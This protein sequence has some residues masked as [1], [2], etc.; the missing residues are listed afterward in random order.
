MASESRSGEGSV[1]G[2][3]HPTRLPGLS[4]ATVVDEGPARVSVHDRLVLFAFTAGEALVWCRG[5]THA[6]A[7]GSLLV[8]EPGDVHREIRKTP[9]RAVVVELHGDLVRSLH[10]TDDEPGLASPIDRGAVL[11]DA[12]MALHDAVRARHDVAVQERRAARVVRLVTLFAKRPTPRPEP[13]LV[14][15]VR[16]ALT[17]SSGAPLSLEELASRL[18][19][20]PTYLCRVFSKHT[21]VGPH[22]YQLQHRLLEARRLVEGGRTVASAAALTGF[23]D[24][25]HLRRHFRRRFA[26]APGRYQQALHPPAR[27]SDGS[28]A[29]GSRAAEHRSFG[30][31]G[32]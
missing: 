24:E 12:V 5:E 14:A 23:G 9:Y 29:R 26:V 19:C 22:A 1:V 30:G 7:P 17:E 2:S 18:R 27:P 31:P 13:P 28:A 25:G 32:P 6:L 4:C 15:R 21:G 8:L 10:G 3:Y 16:R 20:D 11:Y